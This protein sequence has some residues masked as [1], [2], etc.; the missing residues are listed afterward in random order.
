M[1]EGSERVR[2]TVDGQVRALLTGVNEVK[3]QLLHLCGAQVCRV[4]QLPAGE[5]GSMAAGARAMP[6]NVQ[7]PCSMSAVPKT[8]NYRQS[9]KDSCG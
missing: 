7:L 2:V 4:D 6:E 1:V 5:A 9:E 3:R 8:V